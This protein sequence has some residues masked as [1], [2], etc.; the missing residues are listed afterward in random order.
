MYPQDE[1]VY[2]Q[3]TA[4]GEVVYQTEPAV[5]TVE[6]DAE[7]EVESDTLSYTEAAS[8]LGMLIPQQATQQD[9]GQG[10]EQQEGLDGYVIM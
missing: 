7:A 1:V 4:T 10:Q 5:S 6:V 9:H 2:H 8:V 3:S